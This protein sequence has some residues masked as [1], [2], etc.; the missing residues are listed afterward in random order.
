MS[1][2]T[3]EAV[4]RI[5]IDCLSGDSGLVDNP[6]VLVIEG[7]INRF[8]LSKVK[9]EIHRKDIK[10]LL[11]ELP[12]QF[13]PSLMGGA[14]GW[15]FLQ[16]C[17]DRNDDQWGEHSNMEQLC[18]LGL[19]TDMVHWCAPRNLWSMLPGGMPYLLVDTEAEPT[20]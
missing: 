13:F 20:D 5:F 6:D 9:V 14:G 11:T 12:L 1:A 10:D 19:A 2:L 17:V 16:M 7:I 8:A 18:V 15:S 3:A 4:N